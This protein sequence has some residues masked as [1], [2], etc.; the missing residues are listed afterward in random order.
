MH[1]VFID[2]PE[3]KL[4]RINTSMVEGR[5]SIV[6]LHYLIGTPRG[7]SHILESHRLGLFTREEMQAALVDAGLRV[8][9]DEQGLT[10]RGLHVGFRPLSDAEPRSDGMTPADGDVEHIVT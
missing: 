3:L 4:A 9:Y 6:D 8:R 10:G 1:A 7:T 2:E 5:T